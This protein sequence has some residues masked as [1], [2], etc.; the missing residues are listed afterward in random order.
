M[1]FPALAIIVAADLLTGPPRVVVCV[2][3]RTAGTFTVSADRLQG[4]TE[5]LAPTGFWDPA[6]CHKLEIKLP[7][8]GDDY[9]NVIVQRVVW[10]GRVIELAKELLA[11]GTLV[12]PLD[13]PAA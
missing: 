4:K 11:N 7:A 10:N 12:V 2:D 9:R 1:Q 13:P 8:E 3:G 6:R 5:E